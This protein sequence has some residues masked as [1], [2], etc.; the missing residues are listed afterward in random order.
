MGQKQHFFVI[1]NIETNFF[2]TTKE[3]DMAKQNWITTETRITHFDFKPTKL[4]NMLISDKMFRKLKA[5][6]KK[7]GVK[8]LIST[9]V[10]FGIEGL[11][12]VTTDLTDWKLFQHIIPPEELAEYKN[13]KRKKLDKS[14]KNTANH[15]SDCTETPKKRKHFHHFVNLAINRSDYY[16]IQKLHNRVNTFSM[17]MIIRI[18]I[19]IFLNLY[20]KCGDMET[21]IMKL[22]ET[23]E[24][25]KNGTTDCKAGFILLKEELEDSELWRAW[26]FF[27]IECFDEKQNLTYFFRLRL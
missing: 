19:E 10:C 14:A 9:I 16:E 13:N 15:D 26:A 4:F 24:N 27:Q 3:A 22:G 17:A 7:N 11:S 12:K 6:S 5:I 20:E 25:M 18:L 23:I 8:T 21:A 2:Y 1:T